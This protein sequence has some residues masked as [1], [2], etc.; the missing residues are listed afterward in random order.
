MKKLIIGVIAVLVLVV[1]IVAF[2]SGDRE[3]DA[4]ELQD[5][6]QDISD[7]IVG[8]DGPEDQI[9][10]TEE[11]DV[12]INVESNEAHFTFEINGEENPDIVVNQGDMVRIVYTNN[13]LMPHDFVIDEFDIRTPVIN[14][15]ETAII[16]FVADQSGT[17]E[18]YC[19]VG[20]HRAN[21]M[22]GNFVVQ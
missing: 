11:V 3:L 19:A 14:Q 2:Q 17:F 12:T 21:G 16:E 8:E 5:I 20:Q 13:N 15:G 7:Q 4:D 9:D 6:A 22:F 10:E 18:Y 1:A